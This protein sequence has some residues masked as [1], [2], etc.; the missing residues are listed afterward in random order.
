MKQIDHDPDEVPPKKFT[1]GLWWL[2][3]SIIGLLWLHQ[4]YFERFVW[5]QLCLGIGTGCILT[6]WAFALKL[7]ERGGYRDL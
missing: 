3:W 2:V 7:S 5:E 6:A 1:A 4:W